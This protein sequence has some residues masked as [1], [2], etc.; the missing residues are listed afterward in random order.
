MEKI[1]AGSGRII[2]TKYGVMPKITLHRD[3]VNTIVKYMKDNK[4]DFVTLV[5]KQKRETVEGKPTHYLEIDQYKPN[6]QKDDVFADGK[7]LPVV[8]QADDDNSDVPFA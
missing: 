5:M 4:S 2:E 7:L 8:P 3:N 6:N 1:F